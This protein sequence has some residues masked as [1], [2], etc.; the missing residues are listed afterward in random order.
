VVHPWLGD[1]SRALA[2]ELAWQ[3][4][5][6][7]RLIRRPLEERIE[8]GICQHPLEV[9]TVEEAGRGR[10]RVRLRAS[11]TGILHD[12]ITS[13]DKVVLTA[14]SERLEGQSLGSEG[15]IHEVLLEGPPEGR[16]PYTL[17]LLF[18]PTTFVRYQQ[19]LQRADRVESRLRDVLLG[20]EAVSEPV[21]VPFAGID[22]DP[23]QRDAVREALAARE[24]ALIHGPP[25]TGKT[26]VITALLAELVRGGDRPWALA[27]SNAATD[28]LA[29]RASLRGLEVVRLGTPFRISSAAAP[30]TIEARISRGPFAPVL[31]QLD[32]DLIRARNEGGKAGFDL[33]RQ[34]VAERDRI[35]ADA[36]R[37]V[38]QG[39][40][41][42]ASTLGTMA[43]E[44]A[45]LPVAHTAVVD[46]ATQAMEPAIWSVVP[47]ISRLVLVGDPRQLGSVVMS[48]GNVLERSMLERLLDPTFPTRL[49]LPML[50]VQRRM[51][52]LI[53][54]LVADLYG[55]RLTDHPSV[56]GHLLTGLPRV[57]KNGLGSAAITWIDTAGAGLDEAR[58]PIS[59][60]LYNAGEIRVITMAVQA[61]FE[62]GVSPEDIGV[63]APYTAQVQRLKAALP[64]VEVATVNAFQGREKEAILC[65]F[66]R[67]NPD[68]ELGF[69]A[70][71]RRMVVALTR[72]RRF[73]L[74]VGDAATL[75]RHP[76]FEAV[77]ETFAI[78]DAVRSVFEA[79]WSDAL[80]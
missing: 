52:A 64:G 12:G 46:E 60:S 49:P 6:H 31:K 54:Q 7:R 73:L 19:G 56:A 75:G 1:L 70:D 45:M 25:G 32:R 69:V 76:A 77:L 29:V 33:R 50:S 74:C 80:G 71:I 37:A 38:L 59:R 62:Q 43:K 53:R 79:P 67:S 14:G 48:P 17:T 8:A 10:A 24:V 16:G 13:G 2:A 39:A 22:L 28:H 47:W 58:D 72:A 27:D 41:V 4:G 61:L 42:I 65:S 36:R 68:G 20:T 35:D 21:D 11:S 9:D 44:A 3:E 23:S 34:L 40:Q 55:G 78:E 18:D 66:V 30:L 5:E 15:R 63:I 51:N 26:Q 57:E